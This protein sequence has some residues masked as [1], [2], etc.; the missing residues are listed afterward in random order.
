M[1]YIQILK[2]SFNLLKRKK[3]LLLFGLILSL[4]SQRASFNSGLNTS[5]DNTDRDIEQSIDTFQ[6][7]LPAAD[8]IIIV[9]AVLGLLFILFILFVYIASNL[10]LISIIR[11]TLNDIT[12]TNDPKA[13]KLFTSSSKFLPKKIVLDIVIMLPIFLLFILI[14]FTAIFTFMMVFDIAWGGSNIDSTTFLCLLSVSCL[15]VPV[16]IVVIALLSFLKQVSTY[17]LVAKDQGVLS[18][19]KMAIA[20]VK[21]NFAKYLA[22]WLIMFLIGMLL[23]G[24]I[25]LPVG[26]FLSGLM[27]G[28]AFLGAPAVFAATLLS[29]LIMVL[30]N[31][32]VVTFQNIYWTR[33]F[34]GIDNLSKS[35]TP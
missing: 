27:V 22:S 29:W 3:Y 4:F 19:I 35:V 26:I 18:S 21:D 8:T 31:T 25:F 32:P 23:G 2:D 15:L 24:I 16:I 17:Y 1:D 33:V 13:F 5:T 7:I 10:S 34:W 30:L 6:E 9:I 14:V 28:S 20:S 12:G 11:S